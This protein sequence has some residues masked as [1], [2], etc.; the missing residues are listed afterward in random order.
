MRIIKRTLKCQL[1][2]SQVHCGELYRQASAVIHFCIMEK[3]N[4]LLLG[5]VEEDDWMNENY[6]WLPSIVYKKYRK[7]VML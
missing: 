3:E 7:Q 1:Q 5:D 2:G 6:Y 4:Y